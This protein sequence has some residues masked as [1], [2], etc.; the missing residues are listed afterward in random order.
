[1]LRPP[2]SQNTNIYNFTY[3][4]ELESEFHVARVLAKDIQNERLERDPERPKCHSFSSFLTVRV[5]M[6]DESAS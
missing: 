2:D 4:F 3:V 1:M 5:R 6:Q